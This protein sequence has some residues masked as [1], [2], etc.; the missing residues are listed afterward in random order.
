VSKEI[1]KTAPI[2]PAPLSPLR[3]ERGR[4]PFLSEILAP[5]P[6]FWGWGWGWG[7]NSFSKN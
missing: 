2:P 3:G 6:I 4:K 5:S 7:Q 1:I